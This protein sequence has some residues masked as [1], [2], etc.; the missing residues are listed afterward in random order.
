MPSKEDAVMEKDAAM[1]GSE[2]AWSGYLP[3]RAGRPLCALVKPYPRPGLW[4]LPS[5]PGVLDHW[6]PILRR[7]FDFLVQLVDE[8]GDADRAR[9]AREARAVYRAFLDAVCAG[10]HLEQVPTV[11][12]LTLVREA[13]VAGHA[14]GDPFAR[15][16]ERETRAALQRLIEAPERFEAGGAAG[17]PPARDKLR[18]LSQAAAGNLFDLGSPL[19]QK[20]YRSGRMD[21]IAGLEAM[22]AAMEARA[23][24]EVA[25][26]RARGW[27][28]WLLGREVAP[29]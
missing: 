21:F 3:R 11:H 24:E 22:R 8:E 10:R 29:G 7:N 1:E 26:L 20:S 9:R 6:A 14:L 2:A 13:I 4:W 19:T 15:V 16:K 27:R 28:G 23:P 25:A 12:H 18:I 5:E 17:S